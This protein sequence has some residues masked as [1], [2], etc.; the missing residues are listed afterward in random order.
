MLLAQRTV[1]FDPAT[2]G[3]AFPNAFVNVVLTL[4]NGAQITT[5]GRCGGMAYAA[6]DYF[7]PGQPVPRWRSDLYAPEPRPAGQP[8][9]R[10]V[11][12]V[13]PARLVPHRLRRQV[14]HLVPALRRPHLG[15][16]GRHAVDQ[17]GGAAARHGLDRPRSARRPG[18]RHRAQPRRDRRQPPGRRLRVRAVGR[19]ARRRHRLRQQHA[20]SPG[21]PHVLGG[22]ARLDRL[23]R[24][25][26]ARL[27][28]AGLHAQVP[29]GAHPP[30]TP[31]PTRPCPPGTP[32]SSR[33]SGPA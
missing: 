8:L 4:P 27:L 9:A 5:A 6:L 11:L 2:H 13:P 31:T 14:R 32:S 7:L 29:A 25:R 17:G 23:Q 30:R 24:A 26:L 12:H 1:A 19:R 33:T 15:V 20:R 18:P 22:P 28:R 21:D 3:F 10:P 16:Q